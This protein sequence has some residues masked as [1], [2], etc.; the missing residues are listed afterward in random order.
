MMLLVAHSLGQRSQPV[1]TT[2]RILVLCAH[3]G[4]GSVPQG[5]HPEGGEVMIVE[6][7]GYG[8][9]LE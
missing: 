8:T 5:F 9:N 6:R 2:P 1:P 3:I 4:H 7:Q